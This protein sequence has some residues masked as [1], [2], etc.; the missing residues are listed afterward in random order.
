MARSVRKSVRPPGDSLKKPVSLKDLANSLGLSATTISLVLNGSPGVESIPKE[1]RDRV[2]ECAR[3]L[4]YRPNFLASALRSKRTYTIGV[5]VPELSDGYSALV[6]GGIEDALLENGYMYLATSHRHS[7]AQITKLSRLLWERR[8]EGLILVDTPDE[9]KI[10]LPIVSV[11]GHSTYDGITN[12]VLD[13]NRAAELGVRHLKDLGHRK[14]AVLK[15]Q[16]FSSDTE[17]RWSAIERVARQLGVPI[18][19]ALVVQ[20][21]GNSPSPETGYQ[22]ALRLMDR[23][24]PFT[25]FFA[26]ND[27]SAVGAIRAFNERGRLVP[28]EISVVGFDDIWS[29]AFHIPA[30]TTVRQPLR[31]MGVQAAE[32]LMQRIQR[33]DEPDYPRAIEVPPELVVRESTA[34]TPE[35]VS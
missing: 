16:H 6:V 29:A 23:G 4:N 9:I 31:R 10:P 15:G 28:Q 3:K 21:E 30:L 24:V 17:T 33:R 26:F 34:P 14:I 13:H 22:A 7:V 35:G 27:V 2:I 11:S 8:I 12:I 19:P 32:T 25:G 1:T 18:D 5:M 20:L